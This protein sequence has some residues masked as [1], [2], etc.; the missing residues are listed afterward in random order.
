M[1]L[2]IFLDDSAK[3]WYEREIDA[4][5]Q[6]WPRL[7]T[8]MIEYFGKGEEPMN[9]HLMVAK[10]RQEDGEMVH[11]YVDQAAMLLNCLVATQADNE[12][13]VAGMTQLALGRMVDERKVSF[14]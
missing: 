9:I 2:P 1:V 5:R 14:A 10:L 7:T 12:G 3:V 4:V 11:R 8:T 13:F 6:N